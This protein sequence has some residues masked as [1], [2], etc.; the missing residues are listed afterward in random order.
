MN[1]LNSKTEVEGK[2]T[3]SIGVSDD[4]IKQSIIAGDLVKEVSANLDGSGG[5]RK[6]FA[7]AG[8][9]SKNSTAQINDIIKNTIT[10]ILEKI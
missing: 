3:L 8:I 4:L 10:T 2:K 1:F 5:G 9:S 6:D 7:M